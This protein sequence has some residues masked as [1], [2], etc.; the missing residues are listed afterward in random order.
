MKLLKSLLLGSALGASVPT[1]P[2]WFLD[3]YD[4][5]LSFFEFE[6]LYPALKAEMNWNGMANWVKEDYRVFLRDCHLFGRCARSSNQL[7]R[8]EI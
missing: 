1:F 3:K 4:E 7:Q 5:K 2:Q 8:Q 6:E